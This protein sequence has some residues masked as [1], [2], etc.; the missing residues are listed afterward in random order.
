MGIRAITS[1]LLPVFGLLFPAPG[2]AACP[3]D[4]SNPALASEWKFLDADGT[5]GGSYALAGGKLELTG[6][7][8]DAFNAVNEFVGIW[9]ADI[10]GDFDVSVKLESQTNTHAWAQAGIAVA[11]DLTDLKKGGYVVLDVTPGNGYNLFY[12]AAQ[13]AGTL[14]KYE[15]A[16]SSGYPVW[17]RLAKAG[18][19]FSA[20]YRK[21]VDLAWTS[22]AKDITPVG[23]P[24]PSQLAL[25]SLSHNQAMDGKVVFDDFACLHAPVA[26]VPRAAKRPAGT[27]ADPL[28]PSA[29]NA[30]G[31]RSSGP[32]LFLRR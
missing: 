27:P 12:D 13:P 1:S 19:K 22:I 6:R 25:M 17:L 14:D 16:A 26:L 21:S 32:V 3:D 20:W 9:R 31:R 5:D 4:F 23:S 24:A 7:G 2:R 10:A 11:T 18:G 8:R 29:W 15:H 30:A 28:F